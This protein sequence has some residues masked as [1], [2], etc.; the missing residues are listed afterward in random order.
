MQPAKSKA[1]EPNFHA[2]PLAFG[3]GAKR[4]HCCR[5]AILYHLLNYILFFILSQFIS[6]LFFAH[7]FSAVRRLQAFIDQNL[8][9]IR[10]KIMLLLNYME[11][12]LAMGK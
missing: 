9:G 1:R 5:F 12:Q 10:M 4:C 2:S 11:L 8:S 7:Q 6:Y 3:N